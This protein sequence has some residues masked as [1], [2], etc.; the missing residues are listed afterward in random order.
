MEKYRYGGVEEADNPAV[1]ALSPFNS[2]VR[3]VAGYFGG[4]TELRAAID[5][6]IKRLYMEEAA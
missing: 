6:L 4:M 2:D 1:F 3:R 5:E